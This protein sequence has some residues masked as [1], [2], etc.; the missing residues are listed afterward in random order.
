[1]RALNRLIV[2]FNSFEHLTIFSPHTCGAMG[3]LF[4]RYISTSKGSLTLLRIVVF[5]QPHLPMINN[6]NLV[7][8][9]PADETCA[10]FGSGEVWGDG[11]GRE[12]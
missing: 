8:S 11:V 9:V 5:P 12:L 1:M 10:L 3:H 6:L 2:A 7:T 4:R